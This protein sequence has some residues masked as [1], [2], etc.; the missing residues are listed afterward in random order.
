DAPLERVWQAWTDPAK[1][2]QWWG[3]HGVTNPTCEWDAKPGGKIHIV[4]LA[5]KELGPMAGQEW[6]M[7]GEFQTVDAPKKLVFTS[8]PL[9]DGKP[10]MDT[11]CTVT[12]EAQGNQTKLSILIEV[13]RQT[14]AAEGPLSG[15]AQGWSQQIDKLTANLKED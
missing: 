3:P 11:R 5:G 7:S 8:S 14:P 13:T 9:Q 1:L 12:F 2:Q 10:I 6:P 15:M 4:M